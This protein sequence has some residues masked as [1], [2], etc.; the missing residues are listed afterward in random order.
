MTCKEIEKIKQSQNSQETYASRL[1][2]HKKDQALREQIEDWLKIT[3]QTVV[4]SERLEQE[5][6]NYSGVDSS[7]DHIQRVLTAI[8]TD[9]Q[10]QQMIDLI[11][12]DNSQMF[13][14]M[15]QQHNN[16]TSLMA[17]FDA[18]DQLIQK[19]TA[20]KTLN[21]FWRHIVPRDESTMTNPGYVEDLINEFKNE[22]L[23]KDDTITQKVEL[24][25]E[26]QSEIQVYQKKLDRS[27]S[28][29]HDKIVE[30]VKLERQLVELNEVNADMQ[31]EIAN[32]NLTQQGTLRKIEEQQR[33]IKILDRQ[34]SDQQVELQ[35]FETKLNF[36][37]QEVSFFIQS[38]VDAEEKQK[39]AEDALQP[40]T[41]KLKETEKQ[42]FV[43]KEAAA[44]L[45]SQGKQSQRQVLN[46]EFDFDNLDPEVL[47]SLE[48]VWL[49]N[50][51]ESA[52]QIVENWFQSA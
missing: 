52:K 44:K 29:K 15:K 42:V 6:V 12:A 1:I 13:D 26:L 21:R 37:H 31:K 23:V 20:I 36:K 32:F 34:I 3:S 5:N 9:P 47:K 7:I 41:L 24:I 28:E 45:V 4:L 25:G 43:L 18:R 2:S 51:F 8:S 16:Y 10:A 11:T 33:L 22:L 38:A 48:E 39:A 49:E 46:Q 40:L 30:I 19:F 17:D 50:A 35:Q 14:Y 27:Y